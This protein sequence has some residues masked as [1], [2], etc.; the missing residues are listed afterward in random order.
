[1]LAEKDEILAET[2]GKLAEK[3]EILAETKGKLAE[4]ENIINKLLEELN[5]FKKS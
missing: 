4:K 5:K 1:M 3:D 2:K